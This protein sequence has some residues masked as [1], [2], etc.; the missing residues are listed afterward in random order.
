MKK[1]GCREFKNRQ[2]YY[3]RRVRLGETIIVTDRGKPVAKVQP[4]SEEERDAPTLDE[5]LR[6]LEA[7]GHLRLGKGRFTP[8]DPVPA[9]GKPAS[10]IIIEDRKER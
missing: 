8:Y 5:K 2:G 4:V 9:S 6:Q 10:Q 3:L 7:E 1:V